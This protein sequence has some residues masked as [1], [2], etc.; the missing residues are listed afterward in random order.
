MSRGPLQWEIREELL[1][2]WRARR[3]VERSRRRMDR[4]ASRGRASS[5]LLVVTTSSARAPDSAP[6][7]LRE[8]REAALDL[9]ALRPPSSD[10][11][12]GTGRHLPSPSALRE[13]I[14]RALAGRGGSA[15]N[16]EIRNDVAAALQ[17]PTAALSIPHDP[18]RGGRTEFDYRLAWSRTQLSKAKRISR[19][20]PR[21]WKLEDADE[22]V[23]G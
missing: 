12:D 2:D 7:W 6:Q 22:A 18:A 17:L 3:P 21:R 23:G 15:S 14:L 20:G 19:V 13:P 4:D 1:R 9:G 11:V 5:I 10:S 8:G 16:E